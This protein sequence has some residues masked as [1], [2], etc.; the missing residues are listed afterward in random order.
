MVSTVLKGLISAWSP[1]PI[2][3]FGTYYL[4]SISTGNA[5]STHFAG[6]DNFVSVQ[7]FQPCHL[8]GDTDL[9]GIGVQCSFYLQYGAV[10]L[11]LLGGA[12]HQLANLRIALTI[13][14]SAVFIS[15]CV[16]SAGNSL[17]ILGWSL[18]NLLVLPF[19][20][21]TL[22]P[23]MALYAARLGLKLHSARPKSIADVFKAREMDTSSK[24]DN[25][26][27]DN[28]VLAMQA[29]LQLMRPRRSASG[30]TL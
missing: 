5:S 17:A 10:I 27:A 21:F 1:C 16:N 2:F 12:E 4:H 20:V 7:Y 14:A 24:L 29:R 28:F 13:T 26:R 3:H 8:F 22:I 11:A 23:I 30:G 6:T 25:V 15:L 18:F 9:Y 19:P